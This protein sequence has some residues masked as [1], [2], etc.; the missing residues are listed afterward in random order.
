V[1]ASRTLLGN[2]I[3]DVHATE[4]DGTVVIVDYKSH[5][6]EGEDPAAIVEADYTIQRTVYALAALRSGAPRAEIAYL[7]LERPDDPV[8]TTFTAD[9][10]PALETHLRTLAAPVAAGHF[11]PTDKPWQGLCADCPGQPGL[12]SWPPERTLGEKT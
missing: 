3:V 12:C 5:R 2:G 6:L 1:A 9:D 4:P 8:T 11:I 7:F 10:I